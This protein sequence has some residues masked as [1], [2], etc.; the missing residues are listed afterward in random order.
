MMLKKTI[1]FLTLLIAFAL[2]APALATERVVV[3]ELVTN[4]H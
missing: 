1:V 3:G 2:A 4:T